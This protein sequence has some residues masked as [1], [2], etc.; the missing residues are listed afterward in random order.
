MKPHRILLVE[1]DTA[2]CGSIAAVLEDAR[3]IVAA[4]DD[5]QILQHLDTFI[6]VDLVIV[7]LDADTRRIPTILDL[8]E[9]PRYAG[10]ILPVIC[11]CVDDHATCLLKNGSGPVLVKPIDLDELLAAVDAMLALRQ[12]PVDT[13]LPLPLVSLTNSHKAA[14]T[15]RHTALNR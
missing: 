6:Q 3:F 7:D 1:P 10:R 15:P 13:T 2:T 5:L 9:N 8:L 12:W 4:S 11:C 14:D